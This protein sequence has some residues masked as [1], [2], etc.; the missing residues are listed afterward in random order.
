MK[1]D[2][3]RRMADGWPRPEHGG[4]V[5]SCYFLF[6][7]P[8]EDRTPRRTVVNPSAPSGTAGA[9]PQIDRAAGARARGR[10]PL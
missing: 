2:G 10:A 3:R 8:T 1:F 9:E 7:L 5:F 4:A 6:F